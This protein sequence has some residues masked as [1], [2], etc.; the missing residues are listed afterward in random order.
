[1]AKEIM[2]KKDVDKWL[3]TFNH[4][5][6]DFKEIFLNL[7]KKKKIVQSRR[8]ESFAVSAHKIVGRIDEMA[9]TTE[10]GV[11]LL[12][13]LNR[14]YNKYK[15]ETASK[16]PSEFR[17]KEIDKQITESLFRFEN[18]LKYLH[19]SIETVMHIITFDHEGESSFNNSIKLLAYNNMISEKDF[20]LLKMLSKIR[21]L[22]VHNS[23]I[24][25]TIMEVLQPDIPLIQAVIK[26]ISNIYYNLIKQ[27][28]HRL[29]LFMFDLVYLGRV[30]VT[31]KA[32]IYDYISLVDLVVAN[33]EKLKMRTLKYKPMKDIPK[34]RE[35]LMLTSRKYQMY[36]SCLKVEGEIPEEFINS[37]EKKQII[38]DVIQ[39]SLTEDELLPGFESMDEQN[40]F[41][42]IVLDL[43]E[44]PYGRTIKIKSISC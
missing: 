40:K 36:I 37:N 39:N 21:N 32:S 16:K 8:L 33:E 30:G 6:T 29:R 12:D 22:F 41:K 18:D 4:P 2:D 5:D 38:L 44:L 25:E 17:R 13:N 9:V 27:N 19:D 43:D 24:A 10:A 42:D 14:L 35:I 26:E 20:S 3:K 23:T 1:M 31:R 28:E 11:K 7:G 15:D 34:D